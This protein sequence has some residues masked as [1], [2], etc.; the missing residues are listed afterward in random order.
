VEPQVP[1]SLLIRLPVGL[2]LVATKTRLRRVTGAAIATPAFD[3]GSLVL[4]LAPMAIGLDLWDERQSRRERPLP[5]DL[6]TAIV[7]AVPD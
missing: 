5:G 7:L 3:W 4:L 6:Q 2:V 1:I